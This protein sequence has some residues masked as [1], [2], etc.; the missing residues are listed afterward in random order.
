MF[1]SWI[2]RVKC[3]LWVIFSVII[4]QGAMQV[5]FEITF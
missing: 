4:T 1:F 3:L 2:M 5:E